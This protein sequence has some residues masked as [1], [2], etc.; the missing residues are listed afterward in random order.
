MIIPSTRHDMEVM[1]VYLSLAIFQC[2]TVYAQVETKL[3]MAL[4]NQMTVLS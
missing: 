2:E 3:C 4:Y 1:E